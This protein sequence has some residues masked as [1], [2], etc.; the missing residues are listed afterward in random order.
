[1]KDYK[2]RLALKCG[3]TM[4]D[5]DMKCER[6]QIRFEIWRM[7]VDMKSS[8]NDVQIIPLLSRAWR[9]NRG[10]V[11]ASGIGGCVRLIE[12]KSPQQEI[13]SV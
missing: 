11:W 6:S 4:A 3:P 5:D 1:M 2:V 8:R 9:L 13:L 10:H 12:R 7:M